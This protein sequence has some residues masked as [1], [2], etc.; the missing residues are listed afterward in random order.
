MIDPKACVHGRSVL[1]GCADCIPACPHGALRF[2]RGFVRLDADACQGCGA[3]A[4]AC[5]VRAIRQEPPPPEPVRDGAALILVCAR[6][7]AATGRLA[8]ACI[9]GA[10][11]EQVAEWA[12]SGVT[13]IACATGDCGTC[14][15]APAQR[16]AGTLDDLAPLAR[17]AG[18]TPPRAAPASRTQIALWTRRA[19]D[20][21]APARRALLKALTAPLRDSAGQPPALARLQARMPEDAPRA[22]V[23][24]IDPALCSGCDACIRLCPESALTLI[25]DRADGLRY[26]ITPHACTGCLLCEDVCTDSAIQVGAMKVPAP[27]IAL[28]RLDCRACGAT[29]HVPRSGPYASGGLCPVCAASGHHKKL[30]Q[31]LT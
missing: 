2:E 23:P 11:L 22:F 19:G 28:T 4:G 18:L 26:R 21:P 6:H 30:F 24:R 7:P 25:N 17:A 3:C 13:R 15:D 12:L 1:A 20:G 8:P 5:P 27:D 29:V 9:Q 16:L 14:P 10:G 31:V